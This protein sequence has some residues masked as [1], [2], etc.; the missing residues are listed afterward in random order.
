MSLRENLAHLPADVFCCDRVRI[1]PIENENDLL[2]APFDCRM[3][4]EQKD[5]VNPASFS[6]GRAY[7]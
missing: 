2:Y 7:L 4:P 5:L 1:T 6:I 3:Y